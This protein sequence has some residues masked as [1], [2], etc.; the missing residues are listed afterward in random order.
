[1]DGGVPG[2]VVA[3]DPAVHPGNF[4]FTTVDLRGAALWAATPWLS[5]ALGADGFLAPKRVITS[6]AHDPVDPVPPG[7][8]L[9]SGNGTYRLGLAR[10]GLS[11]ILS[12]APVLA[13]RGG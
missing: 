3:P 10:V 8:L 2:A 11:L 9:P 1:M 4:D 12:H 6:S 7:S 5:L 13:R